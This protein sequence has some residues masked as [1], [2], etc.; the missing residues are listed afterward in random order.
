MKAKIK[1]IFEAWDRY[2]DVENPIDLSFIT[3]ILNTR[4]SVFNNP[5]VVTAFHLD[6]TNVNTPFVSQDE[7]N[8][9]PAV[10]TILK[11]KA[12]TEKFVSADVWEVLKE[13]GPILWW[14]TFCPDAPDALRKIAAMLLSLP[15][16]S[17]ASERA[18][19]LCGLIATKLRNRLAVEK[20]NKIAYVTWNAQKLKKMVLSDEDIE[21]MFLDIN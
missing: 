3:L 20:I 12:K 11:M 5:A 9:I 7:R 1:S 15:A 21:C 18:W 13:V 16:S 4:S 8:I 17:A 19:S 14:Q 6:P 10:G 2:E